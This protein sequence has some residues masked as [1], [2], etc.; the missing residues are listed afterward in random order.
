MTDDVLVR[1]PDEIVLD[2][3]EV[4]VVMGA[5][6]LAESAVAP[7]TSEFRQVREAILLLNRKLWP[8]LDDLDEEA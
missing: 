5:L 3:D 1:L 6:D 7:G 2:L 8:G 4:A